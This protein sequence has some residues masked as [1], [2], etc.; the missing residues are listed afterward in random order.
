MPAVDSPAVLAPVLLAAFSLVGVVM[1][2]LVQ[3]E[4]TIDAK[5]DV[6]ISKLEAEVELLR[7]EQSEQRRLKHDALNRAAGLSMTAR[8]LLAGARRCSC[9]ELE[10]VVDLVDRTGVMRGEHD[11]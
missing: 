2:W 4:T 6:R 7:A 3:R 1:R 5:T 10:Q 11:R 8:L 9:G